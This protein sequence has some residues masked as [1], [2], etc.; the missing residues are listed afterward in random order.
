MNKSAIFLLLLA[1]CTAQLLMAQ[2]PGPAI[3][4]PAEPNFAFDDDGGKVQ[5]VPKLE[6]GA[7]SAVAKKYHGGAVMKSTV[8]D[9]PRRQPIRGAHGGGSAQDTSKIPSTS[10]AASAGNEATPTVVRA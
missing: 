8:G 3:D 10:T 4:R 7:A 9:R 2:Q 1:S 5:T 6:L